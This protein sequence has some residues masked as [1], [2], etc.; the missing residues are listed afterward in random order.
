[1][2]SPFQK[3]AHKNIQVSVRTGPGGEKVVLTARK[4][5]KA[6]SGVLPSDGGRGPGTRAAGTNLT[7]RPPDQR[8][9]L[10]RQEE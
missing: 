1:V 5:K 10:E 2:L 4:G 8:I 3:P 9:R 6:L 7:R